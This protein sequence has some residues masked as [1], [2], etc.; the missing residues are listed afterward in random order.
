MI[1]CLGDENDFFH[2]DVVF[3]SQQMNPIWY[4]ESFA[5]SYA[6]KY[7]YLWR[8]IVFKASERL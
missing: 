7:I 6:C 4:K 8:V 2:C 1:K 3:L 5:T